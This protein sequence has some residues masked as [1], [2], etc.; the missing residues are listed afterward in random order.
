MVA[1]KTLVV[2]G[3]AGALGRAVVT[4]LAAAGARIAAVDVNDGWGHPGDSLEDLRREMKGMMEGDKH[5]R[6]MEAW[7]KQMIHEA[8]TKQ[9]E[10]EEARK[11]RGVTEAGVYQQSTVVLTEKE[12]RERQAAL[13]KGQKPKPSAVKS[14]STFEVD[15]T[16]RQLDK[17]KKYR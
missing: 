14:R 3:A 15:A 8:E 17:V 1:G 10:V 16:T 12:I 11:A 4:D 7:S 13:A 2:T 9:K 5:E 6:L